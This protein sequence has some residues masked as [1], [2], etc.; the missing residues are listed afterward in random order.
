MQPS[1]DIKNLSL[2]DKFV[3]LEELWE[4]MSKNVNENRFT[5]QWHLDTLAQ[6]EENIKNGS[7]KFNRIDDVKKRL[8]SL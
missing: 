4:D 8:T 1:L 2:S 7:S 5:P 6:R 3:I